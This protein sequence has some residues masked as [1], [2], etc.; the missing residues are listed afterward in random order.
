MLDRMQTGRLKV[1]SHLER[2]VRGIPPLSPKGRAH[3][4]ENDDL[5]SATRYAMMM[6]RHADVKMKKVEAVDFL[7]LVAEAESTNRAEA[8]EDLRFRFGDQ[9]P[10]QIQNSRTLEDR[11]CAHDQRDRRLRA[12]VVNQMRQQRPRIK[13]H[14][15]DSKADPKI[16]R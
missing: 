4:E 6:K 1:F 11:P 3:R 8:L 9:W 12:Q 10:T 14:P 13:A 7:R 16:A 5:M 15:V 2:L